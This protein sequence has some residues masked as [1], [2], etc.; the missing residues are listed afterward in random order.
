MDY[1]ADIMRREVLFTLLKRCNDEDYRV[2]RKS[3]PHLV[4]MLQTMFDTH[5]GY[6]FKLLITGPSTD[7]IQSDLDTMIGY[8]RV[9]ERKD[10]DGDYYLYIPYDHVIQLS[11]SRMNAIEKLI[12]YCKKLSFRELYLRSMITFAADW[13]RRKEEPV[14]RQK[15]CDTILDMNVSQDQNEVLVVFDELRSKDYL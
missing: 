15:I 2:N 9:H 14:D 8:G 3:F 1:G 5:I 10:E 4:Y 12:E 7:L 6:N 11:N 13:V